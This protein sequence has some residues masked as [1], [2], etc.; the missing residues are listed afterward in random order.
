MPLQNVTLTKINEAGGHDTFTPGMAPLTDDRGVYRI[1]GLPA[2]RYLVSAGSD[3]MGAPFFKRPSIVLTF[4]PG[5]ADENAATAVE[6]SPG[7]EATNVDIKLAS[8][9]KRFKASGRVVSADTGRPLPDTIVA[10]VAT[11]APDTGVPR[12]GIGPPSG[13]AGE[14][15]LEGL[16]PGKYMAAPVLG[17]LS[18]SELYGDPVNFEIVNGDVS[19]LEIRLHQGVGL[20]GFV[21]VEGTSS[22]DISTKLSRTQIAGFYQSDQ[23]AFST[24]SRSQIGA[25][26]SFRL[27]GLRPGKVMFRLF[28]A[29]GPSGLAILRVER[30][31]I[32]ISGPLEVQPGDQITDLRVVLAEP[33][34]VIRGRIRVE[35]GEAPSGMVMRVTAAQRFS[36][37]RASPGHQ[38]RVQP[39]GTFVFNEVLPGEYEISLFVS[40]PGES[41][42]DSKQPLSTQ[43]VMVRN[44][45][46]SEVVLILDVS[47]IKRN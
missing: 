13:P 2:G 9:N 1:Y 3:S 27:R 42:G 29:A 26:G 17:L 14:F 25:D 44:D 19:G 24:F 38:A 4:H 33:R 36:G 10:Y 46:E 12:N 5:V 7:S 21:V 8:S 41:E 40:T 39:N 6:V 32:E 43:T 22:P 18:E 16:D 20:S 15:Q 35:G 31:G 11:E 34:G 28:D 47:R 45:S 23:Q 30:A 37:I